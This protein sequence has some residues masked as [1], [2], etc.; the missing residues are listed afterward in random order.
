MTFDID[1]SQEAKKDVSE[2][3]AWY[4]NIRS[5]LGNRFRADL[6][7]TTSFLRSEPDGIQIR[8]ADVRIIFLKN[9]PYGIHYRIRKII[10]KVM[11]VLHVKRKP[12]W[13]QN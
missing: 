11:A 7:Q 4:E 12:R 3:Y 2:T 8:Y 13:E 1:F 6:R 9:F 10:V 5:G